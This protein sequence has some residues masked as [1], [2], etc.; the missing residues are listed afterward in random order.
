[1]ADGPGGGE[2]DVAKRYVKLIREPG[3]VTPAGIA[4]RAATRKRGAWGKRELAARREAEKEQ[5][6]KAAEEE[7]KAR[8]SEV[9]YYFDPKTKTYT[10]RV[11]ADTPTP[12]GAKEVSQSAYQSSRIGREAQQKFGKIDE[13]AL[14]WIER[15]E[16][17]RGV[18]RGEGRYYQ[19]PE[20]S[21]TYHVGEGARKEL[22]EISTG[23]A[24]R[25]LQQK[26]IERQQEHALRR[27]GIKTDTVYFSPKAYGL[28][29]RKLG[30][31]AKE[32]MEREKLA[33]VIKIKPTKDEERFKY[34]SVS[35]GIQK[36]APEKLITKTEAT[37]QWYTKGEMPLYG[38]YGVTIVK[39]PPEP[40]KK[41][42]GGLTYE[43]EE[44]VLTQRGLMDKDKSPVTG[45]SPSVA[46]LSEYKFKKLLGKQEQVYEEKKGGFGKIALGLGLG[47]TSY[48]IGFV[49][50]VTF[51]F[52]KGFWDEE[53]PSLIHTLKHPSELQT[54][55]GEIRRKPYILA[56][57]VGYGKGAKKLG[58]TVTKRLIETKVK[59][60]AQLKAERLKAQAQAKRLLERT[61]IKGKTPEEI[62]DSYTEKVKLIRK[63]KK[64][65]KY[66]DPKLQK[67]LDE[68]GKA[69]PEE[70][71]IITRKLTWKDIIKGKH[72]ETPQM[73][74]ISEYKPPRPKG[75]G[76]QLAEKPPEFK[77]GKFRLRLPRF[78][79]AGTK[80]TIYPV[81]EYTQPKPKPPVKPPAPK[82]P[83]KGKPSKPAAS[84]KVVRSFAEDVDLGK[85]RFGRVRDM[86][87]GQ[88][89]RQIL[90]LEEEV[91]MRPTPPKV[92]MIYPTM[93]KLRTAAIVRGIT[94]LF[95]V[96]SI[97]TTK[98]I[99]KQTSI[100]RK[101]AA[102]IRRQLTSQLQSQTQVQIQRQIQSQVQ[103]Q[104]QRQSQVQRQIQSQTSLQTQVQ[105]Q[106]QLQAQAQI[107]RQ[108]QRTIQKQVEIKTVTPTMT[109]YPFE[110][111]KKKKKKKK[112]KTFI[113][114]IRYGGYS[115]TLIGMIEV[116][117]IPATKELASRV[118]SGIGIRPQ[119]RKPRKRR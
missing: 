34:P 104:Q 31:G 40:E 91:I 68:I 94:P 5:R 22:R 49:K 1:M 33:K 56:E 47:A 96:A 8:A 48:G 97:R 86:F 95:G 12:T 111:K 63:L 77:L 82:P 113:P 3:A 50:G 110:D 117:T 30:V 57:M 10:Y 81:E 112:F 38:G 37:R 41:M 14:K 92:E 27:E 64:K 35:V 101:A 70:V 46:R 100:Q 115:P 23:E 25:Q 55:G 2:P 74:A 98:P 52:R 85:G 108:L 39:K 36:P 45:V 58:R 88:Q 32:E 17:K 116:P 118:Y 21:I 29:E 54:L 18:G 65:G 28:A 107:Q 75:Y 102:Q 79:K 13:Q 62:A 114:K 84:D 119:V 103:A 24:R 99:V 4:Q 67:Y 44:K 26:A 89:Q 43:A 109:L 53:L 20:G 19:T 71:E 90:I 15:E 72:K 73:E 51:P 16:A 69:E 7:A 80:K 11:G 87:S 105:A 76:T 60:P 9:K 93:G 78:K 42:F 66:Q 59:T 106:T 6:R 83:R 61:K